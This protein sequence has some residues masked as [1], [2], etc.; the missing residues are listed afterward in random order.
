M[1][2]DKVRYITK[3]EFLRKFCEKITYNTTYYQYKE[4]NTIEEQPHDHLPKWF[5]L[6]PQRPD[7][8]RAVKEG[9][10]SH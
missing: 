9:E 4:E 2:P 5:E 6:K 1:V 8:C 7:G 3:K 10:M